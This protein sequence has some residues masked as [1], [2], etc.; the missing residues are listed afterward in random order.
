MQALNFR[1]KEVGNLGFIVSVKQSYSD[2]D[3][4]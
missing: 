4:I 1:I 2:G 3:E